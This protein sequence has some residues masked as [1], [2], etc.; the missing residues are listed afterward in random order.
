[1]PITTMQGEM[2][3]TVWR[4]DRDEGNRTYG[5]YGGRKA[6]AA[7]ELKVTPQKCS[8][9]MKRHCERIV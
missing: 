2:N 4:K 8:P 6:C 5:T 9:L 3:A 7:S 1:M